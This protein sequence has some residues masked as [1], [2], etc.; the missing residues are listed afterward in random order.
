MFYDHFPRAPFFASGTCIVCYYVRI[1]IHCVCAYLRS[2]GVQSTITVTKKAWLTNSAADPTFLSA[3]AGLIQAWNGGADAIILET[4]LGSYFSRPR[5]C[6]R[7]VFVC[8][9]FREGAPKKVSPASYETVFSSLLQVLATLKKHNHATCNILR[10]F[11]RLF[12]SDILALDRFVPADFR[13]PAPSPFLFRACWC[14]SAVASA[15][16]SMPP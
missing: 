16:S 4:Y 2:P 14:C 5:R 15:R 8:F 12:A 1:G 10:S 9:F 6:L 11:L 7:F 3:D 13:E